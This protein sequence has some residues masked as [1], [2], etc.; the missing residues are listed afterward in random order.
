MSIESLLANA[1]GGGWDWFQGAESKIRQAIELDQAKREE[2]ARTIASAWADFYAT[3]G[4]RMALELLF[5]TTLRRTVFFVSLGLP[6]DQAAAF[7]FFREGQNAV[8]Q[9]IARQISA[10]LGETTKPRDT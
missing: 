2:D 8:A 9:E 5:D 6:S 10:G 7:G 4:G 1:A 3:P